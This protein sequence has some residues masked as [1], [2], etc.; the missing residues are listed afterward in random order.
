MYM[1]RRQGRCIAPA[2]TQSRGP[3]RWSVPRNE[4]GMPSVLQATYIL[5][6]FVS[7]PRRHSQ[8]A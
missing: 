6:A 2:L 8:R 1:D 5:E 3:G 7:D 4:G